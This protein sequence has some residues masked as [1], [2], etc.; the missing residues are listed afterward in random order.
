M[1]LACISLLKSLID[2]GYQDIHFAFTRNQP[3][4]RAVSSQSTPVCFPKSLSIILLRVLDSRL[5]LKAKNHHQRHQAAYGE[6]C[7]KPTKTFQ[8]L[9][10]LFRFFRPLFLVPR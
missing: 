7:Y 3:V 9:A 10:F 6:S 8:L 4:K 2:L 1:L 5:I